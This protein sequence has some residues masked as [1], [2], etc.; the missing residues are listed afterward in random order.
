MTWGHNAHHHDAVIAAIPKRARSA[1]DV[2]CGHGE[3]A[4]RLAAHGLDVDALDLDPV[5]VADARATADPTPRFLVGDFLT[6]DLGVYDVVTMVA[7]LHHLPLALALERA[8]SVLAPGGVLVIVG[9]WRSRGL[10]DLAYDVVMFGA[11]RARGWIARR[12]SAHETAT[13]ASTRPAIVAPRETL[14]EI[15]GTAARILPGARVR[16]GLYWRYV[17]VWRTPT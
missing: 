17:L 9:L 1:L 8:R 14:A 5:V 15:R 3:L 6:A 2:G 16:R 10:V 7:V 12:T 11:S 4:A 13:A